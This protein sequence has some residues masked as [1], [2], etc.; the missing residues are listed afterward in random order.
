MQEIYLSKDNTSGFYGQLWDFLLYCSPENSS[1]FSKLKTLQCMLWVFSFP[2]PIM[3]NVLIFIRQKTNEEWIGRKTTNPWIAQRKWI[4]NN[5][6][7]FSIRYRALKDKQINGNMIS[8]P[9][10]HSETH[11]QR[12]LWKM[13]TDMHYKKGKTTLWIACLLVAIQKNGVPAISPCLPEVVRPK[14]SHPCL[15]YHLFS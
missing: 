6:S 8:S 12:T 5:L 14:Q 9:T 2:F 15:A 1:F 11:C 3:I 4:E 13:N 10:L 7:F